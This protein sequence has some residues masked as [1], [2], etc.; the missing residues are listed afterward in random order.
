[1]TVLQVV[2]QVP[3]TPPPPPPGL[4]PNLLVNQLFPVIGFVGLLI[5][6]G[7]A[8][9]WFFK[10]PIAEAIGERLRAKTRQR[11]GDTGENEPER[12]AGLEHHIVTLQ[13][14]LSELAER[15]DFAERMLAE[16]RERKLSAGQ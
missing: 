11:F 4:D 1:M 16:R 13:G 8:I 9:R 3:P 10:S 2:V 15:V 12:I 6:A 5:V 14:Q 7:L